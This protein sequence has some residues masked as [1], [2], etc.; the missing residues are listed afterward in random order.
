M[1]QYLLNQ[2]IT[3]YNRLIGPHSNKTQFLRAYEFLHCGRVS[4][5]DCIPDPPLTLPPVSRPSSSSPN[6][7]LYFTHLGKIQGSSI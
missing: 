5:L 2:S 1:Y 7:P 3:W 4:A 6:A